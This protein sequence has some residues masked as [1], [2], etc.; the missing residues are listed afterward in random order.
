MPDYY[1]IVIVGSGPAGIFAALELSAAV[2]GLK[3]LM[4]EKGKDLEERQC[5]ADIKGVSCVPCKLCS[6]LCGWGGAGAFSDGKLTLTPDVGGFLEEYIGRDNLVSLIGYADD[7]Y[8][9]Y[10]APDTVYGTDTGEVG[11]LKDIASINDLE[12][13][14]TKIRHM[15]T[16]RCFT[17]LRDIREE[18]LKK[19]HV[20]F[21]TAVAK[22]L[23]D[24]KKVTGI[25]TDKGETIN[26][27]YVILAPGREGS[28]WLAGEAEAHDPQQ[29][30]RHR[31]QG[32]GPG[33]DDKAFDRRML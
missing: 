31:R 30:G 14:P 12:L 16:E 29:P 3:V 7:T 21:N 19:V 28:E 26:A 33:R 9:R 32:R 10:G 17:I 11:R 25:V 8:R 6:T 20:R 18:I 13:V 4:L 5:P 22:V 27:K 24:K 2:N 23:T 1:D 15:G